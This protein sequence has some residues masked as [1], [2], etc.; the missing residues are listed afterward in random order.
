[1]KALIVLEAIERATMLVKPRPVLLDNTTLLVLFIG[2]D[3]PVCGGDGPLQHS[4]QAH[5]KLPRQFAGYFIDA[6]L[7]TPK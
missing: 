7:G 3:I 2:H 5:F 1:M 6:A 4:V